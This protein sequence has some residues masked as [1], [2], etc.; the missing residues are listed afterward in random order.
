MNPISPKVIVSTLAT[1]VAT[2]AM[3][4]LLYLPTTEGQAL[5]ES[6]PP[7][8]QVMILAGAAAAAAFIGGYLKGDP[9]RHT[10]EGA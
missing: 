8:V 9:L 2:A 7:I 6:L 4:G 5:L 1:V 10:D 3:A